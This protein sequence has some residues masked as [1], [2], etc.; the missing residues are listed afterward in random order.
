MDPERLAFYNTPAVL[1]LVLRIQAGM[2]G[3]LQRAL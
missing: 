2:R 3:L 1:S